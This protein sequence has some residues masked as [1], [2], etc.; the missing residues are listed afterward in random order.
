M[1]ATQHLAYSIQ[2]VYN[3]YWDEDIARKN[4]HLKKALRCRETIKVPV[5]GTVFIPYKG[6]S[7][8]GSFIPDFVYHV[9]PVTALVI[10]NDISEDDLSHLKFVIETNEGVTVEPMVIKEPLTVYKVAYLLVLPR[11]TKGVKN[12]RIV[13]DNIEIPNDLTFEVM[14][15]PYNY[16]NYLFALLSKEITLLDRGIQHAINDLDSQIASLKSRVT[17]IENKAEG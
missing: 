15:A 5:S 8:D 9:I 3:L 17:A 11:G 14:D 16:E 7:D 6:V 12:V 10:E 4:M 2:T 13:S 1:S